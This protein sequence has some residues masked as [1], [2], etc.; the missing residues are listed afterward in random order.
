[1][2]VVTHE[3]GDI[4]NGGFAKS[5]QAEEALL[6]LIAS[7]KK[8]SYS[9]DITEGKNTDWDGVLGKDHVEVKFSAKV[10]KGDKRLSNFFETHYKNGKPSAL[11]LTKA[12]KYITVTPG[13]SNKYQMLTGKV[14][15]WDVPALRAA[16]AKFAIEEGDFGEKGFFV[17]NK[18]DVVPHEW[19]GDVFFDQAKY[20][21]DISKWI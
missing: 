2:L 21:F 3:L 15:V 17:P 1:M 9:V 8:T 4:A 6:K 18:S 12:D 7:R 13:W 16:V 19:V 5:K 14:R 10:Y 20:C 11:L